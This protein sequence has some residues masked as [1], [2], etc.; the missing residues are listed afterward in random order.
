[1]S[2]HDENSGRDLA[3][4]VGGIAVGLIGSRLL[5]PII[6]RV[7]GAGLVRVGGDPFSRLI[8]DHRRIL[9]VLDEMVAA[10]SGSGVE[11]ARLFM[12]L[13]RKLAKHAMAEEDVVYPLLDSQ[14]GQAGEA[15]HLY[16]EHADMKILLYRLEELL[17]S[18]EDWSE[19]ARSL[20][21]SIRHHSQDEETN[22]F[23]QL[24]EKV[25]KRQLPAVSGLI[26][27]EE[28]MVL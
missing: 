10:P 3:I 4:F 21:D 18:G 22:V 25:S 9:A 19:P 14:S 17:K 15:K 8:D 28:A 1:M 12:S 7:S 6:A 11:R 23:P 5:P 24:R 27:R 26:R 16:S 2:T 13:K 20:R